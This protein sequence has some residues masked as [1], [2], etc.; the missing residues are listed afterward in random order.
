MWVKGY[1]PIKFDLDG[2]NVWLKIPEFQFHALFSG[3]DKKSVISVSKL[4]LDVSGIKFQYQNKSIV[5]PLNRYS[6]LNFKLTPHEYLI[7]WYQIYLKCRAQE[8]KS[9]IK[10]RQETI[11]SIIR[12]HEQNLLDI[13][14]LSSF[15]MS[16]DYWDRL[17]S[18]KTRRFDEDGD[19]K[20]YQEYLKAIYY[21]KYHGSRKDFDTSNDFDIHE[22][23]YKPSKCRYKEYPRLFKNGDR[24]KS[25]FAFHQHGVPASE[26]KHKRE[27][28]SQQV[29]YHK[30]EI[31]PN[32]NTNAAKSKKLIR[33]ESAETNY[34][35][36][37]EQRPILLQIDYIKV[38]GSL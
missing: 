10:N 29:K 17:S 16:D 6:G 19:Y 25:A 20:Y 18:T 15:L 22:D 3:E 9:Q 5:L 28:I 37:K 8:L 21:K 13:E 32:R 36:L 24:F 23:D 33:Q 12:N 1:E 2:V 26:A 14:P 27:F 31:K 30:E 34:K 35:N 11:E 7:H 4:E 38:G